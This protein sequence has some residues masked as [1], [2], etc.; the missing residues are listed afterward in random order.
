[1][2]AQ[3]SCNSVNAS[4]R[5]TFDEAAAFDLHA[6]GVRAQR[7][8]V[9]VG[10]I[11]AE[12]SADCA[13]TTRVANLSWLPGASASSG[14]GARASSSACACAPLASR[15]TDQITASAS[16]DADAAGYRRRCDSG[17]AEGICGLLAPRYREFGDE[18]GWSS[19][20]AVGAQAE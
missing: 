17:R 10:L 8:V 16:H 14:A 4:E 2:S 12:Y 15:S 11:T 18:N 13:D 6:A 1:M 9:I 5:E 19:K 20:I 3:L 7:Q